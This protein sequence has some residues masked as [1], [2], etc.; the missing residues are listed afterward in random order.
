MLAQLLITILKIIPDYFFYLT[1][2]TVMLVKC[3]ITWLRIL[4]DDCCE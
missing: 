2:R 3:F 4:I 1:G